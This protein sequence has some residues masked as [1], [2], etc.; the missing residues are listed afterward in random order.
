[1]LA[2]SSDIYELGDQLQYEGVDVTRRR[3]FQCEQQFKQVHR[4]LR[5][6]TK[7]IR[8][9]QLCLL[10]WNLFAINIHLWNQ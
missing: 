6:N 1:M 3:I 9:L 10:V 8:K 2:D 5:I 4:K 7:I